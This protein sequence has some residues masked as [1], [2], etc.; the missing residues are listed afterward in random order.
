MRKVSE[1]D[2]YLNTLLVDFLNDGL[3]FDIVHWWKRIGLTSYLLISIL[4]FI[5][6]AIF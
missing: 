3:D 2:R 4:Q 5:K 1:L 6:G